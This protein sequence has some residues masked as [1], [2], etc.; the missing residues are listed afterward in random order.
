M[1]RGSTLFLDALDSFKKPLSEAPILP[2]FSESDAAMRSMSADL[3]SAQQDVLGAYNEGTMQV[4]NSSNSLQ[5]LSA[6]QQGLSGNLSDQLMKLAAQ[7]RAMVNEIAGQKVAY[8]SGKATTNAQT[9]Y[10]NRI[11]N[12]QNQ[13][14]R[15]QFVERARDNM[16]QMGMH[17]DN[18]DLVEKQTAEGNRIL[19]SMGNYFKI[20]FDERGNPVSTTIKTGKKDGD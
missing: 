2:D 17:L 18:M 8:E 7:K 19:A 13:A 9:K 11:D 5:Q 16:L 1:A 6:R 12:L 3:T 4:R 20:L 10:Q 14:A 15:Q